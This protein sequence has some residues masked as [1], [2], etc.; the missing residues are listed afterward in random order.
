[1]YVRDRLLKCHKK[2]RGENHQSQTENKSFVLSWRENQDI[3]KD[4]EILWERHRDDERTKEM[5][6]EILDLW[7]LGSYLRCGN[8]NY[9]E[10]GAWIFWNVEKIQFFVL[11]FQVGL[12]RCFNFIIFND[13]ISWVSQIYWSTYPFSQIIGEVGW[14][15]IWLSGLVHS[16]LFDFN[17]VFNNVN[18]SIMWY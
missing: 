15:G 9:I 10:K 17:N 16:Q 2:P 5:A 4:E 12:D 1:M 14:A 6:N 13:S 8:W 3:L 7:K 18:Y 11:V